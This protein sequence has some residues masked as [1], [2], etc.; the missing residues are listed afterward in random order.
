[1]GRTPTKKELRCQDVR[2]AIRYQLKEELSM[3]DDKFVQRV[4]DNICKKV[5]EVLDN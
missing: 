4:S 1:M 2:R 5:M 3:L